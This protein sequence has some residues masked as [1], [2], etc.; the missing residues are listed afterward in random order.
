MK[1]YN[2]NG[3]HFASKCRIVIYEKAAPVEIVPIP[4]DNLKSP[5]YLRIYPL[6]KTPA[7]AVDGMVIGESEIINEYLEETFP[8]PSLLPKD[9]QSRARAR[10]FGRFSDLYLEPLFHVLFPQVMGA[11]KD[12]QLITTTLAEISTRLDQLEGML[13]G[14]PYAMG[15]LF[16]LGDCALAPLM[17][18]ANL[19]LAMLGVPGFDVG[20]PKVASWWSQVQQRPAVQKVHAQQQEAVMQMQAS[21]AAR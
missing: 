5:E 10:S 8:L 11:E 17:F 3:S 14:G 12:Q 15:D 16:S 6:G 4:G 20:S 2:M 7:L 19:T 18:Y 13:S 9:P 21:S 1:L